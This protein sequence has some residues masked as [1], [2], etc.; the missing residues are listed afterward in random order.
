VGKG[1]ATPSVETDV[2]ELGSVDFSVTATHQTD[3]ESE[4]GDFFGGHYQCTLQAVLD[5]AADFSGPWRLQCLGAMVSIPDPTQP[6]LGLDLARAPSLL[7]DGF[8]GLTTSLV[9]LT[10]GTVEC[11]GTGEAL[12]IGQVFGPVGL[13][14]KGGQ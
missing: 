3:F 8:D 10:N 11:P 9:R 5:P 4:Q 13:W 14:K 7:A 2:V 1:A 6:A 12:R